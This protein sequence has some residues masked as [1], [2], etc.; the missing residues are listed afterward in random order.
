MSARPKPGP[1]DAPEP[2]PFTTAIDVVGGRWTLL[3]MFFL[4]FSPRRFNELQ[5]LLPGVSHKVLTETLRGLEANGLVT[6][7]VFGTRPPH[8]EY[9]MSAYGETVRPVIEAMRAWGW[10]HLDKHGTVGPESTCGNRRGRVRA[11]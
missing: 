2:C 6:R 8:V 4:G 11:T 10:T 1:E 3:T 9:A 5:R 7:R